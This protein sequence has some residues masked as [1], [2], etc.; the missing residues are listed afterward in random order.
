MNLIGIGNH[1]FN[2]E[3]I[4]AIVWN[5]KDNSIVVSTRSGIFPVKQITAEDWKMIKKALHLEDGR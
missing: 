5:E 4:E 1:I 2:V 3:H